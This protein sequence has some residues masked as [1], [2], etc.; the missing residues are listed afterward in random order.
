MVSI[1]LA[2]AMNTTSRQV[3]LDLEVVVAE[4][5]V[6]GRVEHLEQRRGRV[7]APAAGRQLVDLVEQ[8]DR[9]HGAGLGDGPDDAAGLRAD[10]GAA[11]AADLGLVAHAAEGDA[12]ERAAHGPGHALAEAGLAHAGRPD[13]R[14]DGAGAAARR[15]GGRGRRV[16]ALDGGVG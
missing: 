12:D 3:E 11:V 13:E 10:V 9:V 7:A 1:T 16:V 14:D 6:L 15:H 2:V 8:H 4:R 5:V